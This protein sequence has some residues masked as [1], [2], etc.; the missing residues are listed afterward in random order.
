MKEAETRIQAEQ[1][2]PNV[3]IDELP[4]QTKIKRVAYGDSFFDSIVFNFQPKDSAVN[5]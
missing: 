2:K 5:S 4:P 3:S 1:F